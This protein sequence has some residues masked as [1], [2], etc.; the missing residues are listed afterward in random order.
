MFA[1]ETLLWRKGNRFD[2]AAVIPDA[3]DGV[4][5]SLYGWLVA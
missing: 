5:A 3:V 2:I 4:F 1:S